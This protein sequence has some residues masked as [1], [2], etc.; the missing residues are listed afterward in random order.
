MLAD[1]ESSQDERLRD[2]QHV[3]DAALS[4]LGTDDLLSTLLER[5][6][7][8]VDADTSTVL[9]LDT[10]NGVLVARSSRGVEEEV[11]QGVRIPLGI[12]FAG[13]IATERR[14]V[15]IERVDATTVTNPILWER[16]IEVMLGVPMLAAGELVGVLHV[17]RC[18]PEPFTGQDAEILSVA[19]ERVAMAIQ[20]EQRHQAQAATAALIDKLR[21]GPAPHC[22]GLEFATRYLP[23]EHGGAGGDWYDLFL[24][25]ADELWIIVGDVAG[26]GLGAAITMGRIQSTIRAY[27]SIDHDPLAVLERADHT[28]RRFD[29]GVMVTAICA[30]M[31]PPYRQL[32]IATAGH[33]PPVLATPHQTPELLSLPVGPPLGFGANQ[34]RSARTIPFPKGSIAVLYTDGLV[35]RRHEAID[36]SLERLRESVPPDSTDSAERVCRDVLRR[37]VGP[38]PLQDDAALLV[39]HAVPD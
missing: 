21:P 33:P 29:P 20:T 35:E 18:R 36:V 27:A 7:R 6:T 39:V 16:G 37:H 9:L 13:R 30:V 32:R 28:L 12:G 22:P 23:A 38:E 10:P 25:D 5:V 24:G 19:A 17:G 34:P 4:R 2:L 1:P 31:P 3:T 14:P 11:R 15:M 26:H 8:I